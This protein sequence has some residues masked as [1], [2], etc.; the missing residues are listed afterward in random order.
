MLAAEKTLDE[1]VRLGPI[2]ALGGAALLLIAGRLFFW[3]RH[4]LRREDRS[5]TDAG[6]RRLEAIR[7]GR[8]RVVLIEGIA[9]LAAALGLL[10]TFLDLRSGEAGSIRPDADRLSLLFAPALSGLGVFVLCRGALGLFHSWT[11]AL[12]T[13]TVLVPPGPVVLPPDI[14]PP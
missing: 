7:A 10:A 6:R 3:T 5:A 8:K 9:T 11:E 12:R 13:E 4:F 1:V 2:V 14:L